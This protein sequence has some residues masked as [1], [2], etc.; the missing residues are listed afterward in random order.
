[1]LLLYF[2]FKQFQLTLIFLW[3]WPISYWKALRQA[4]ALSGAAGM[5]NTSVLRLVEKQPNLKLNLK[6]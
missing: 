3:A 4:L 6:P 2:M 5:L 1:M